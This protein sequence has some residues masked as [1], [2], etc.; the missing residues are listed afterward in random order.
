MACQRC[1]SER[2]LSVSAKCSDLCH[3][4]FMEHEKDGYAPDLWAVGGGDY[5]EYDVCLDCGQMQGEFP[6]TDDQLREARILPTEEQ[7]AEKAAEEEQAARFEAIPQCS[8]KHRPGNLCA[9][10]GATEPPLKPV[11]EILR[12]RMPDGGEHV[13]TVSTRIRPHTDNRLARLEEQRSRVRGIQERGR[14]YDGTK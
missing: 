10:C 8:E 1:K 5:I 12:S 13:T 3:C 4:Y 6:I 14:P 9:A 2:V 7:L 11:V